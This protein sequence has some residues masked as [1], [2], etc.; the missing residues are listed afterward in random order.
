MQG[1]FGPRTAAEIV[2][3]QDAE[4]FKRMAFKVI[5]ADEI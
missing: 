2:A 5:K 4:H 1:S 3:R